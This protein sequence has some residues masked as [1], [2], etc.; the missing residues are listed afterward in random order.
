M[1]LIMYS[2]RRVDITLN[3]AHV[4]NTMTEGGVEPCIVQVCLLEYGSDLCAT[5]REIQWSQ[6]VSALQCF[7]NSSHTL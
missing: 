5:V 4:S 2:V 6:A 3:P 1:A 7:I